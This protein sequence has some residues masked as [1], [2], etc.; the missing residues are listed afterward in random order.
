MEIPETVK[1]N[2]GYRSSWT[3]EKGVEVW[4]VKGK[5]Y[6]LQEDEKGEMFGKQ[7]FAGPLRDNGAQRTLIKQG[8]SIFTIHLVRILL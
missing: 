7:K 3:K 4:D 2:E 5:K 8:S 6:N 1:Q